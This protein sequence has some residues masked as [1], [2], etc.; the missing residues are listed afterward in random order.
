MKRKIGRVGL[1]AIF[2][3]M[4]MTLMKVQA[5]K[6]EPYQFEPGSWIKYKVSAD[7]NATE[8][9]P[10][11]EETNKIE[12]IKFILKNTAESSV[13]LLKVT[14]FKNK[15]QMEEYCKVDLFTGSG[16]EI[17][18]IIASNLGTGDYIFN[19]S[20]TSNPPQIK[21][22]IWGN[23]LGVRRE[24]NVAFHTEYFDP[25]GDNKAD[26]Q[27]FWDKETGILCLCEILNW[28]LIK[29]GAKVFTLWRMEL[30]DKSDNLW[31][32]DETS[33]IT[34]IVVAAVITIPIIIILAK[35]LK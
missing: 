28:E 6:Y 15:T 11:V 8:T 13:T 25:F 27:F 18:V 32:E 3:L 34:G 10:L 19:S 12:W 30:I 16:I 20:E 2:L 17:P 24:I 21:E 14:K 1:L 5:T 35:K 7:S 23:I 29:G 33:K 31:N 22:T 26:L 4:I 9:P